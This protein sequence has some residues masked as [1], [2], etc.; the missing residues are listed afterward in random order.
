MTLL[1]GDGIRLC[2]ANLILFSAA[3]VWQCL[4]MVVFGT[5]ARGI[6]DSLTATFCIGKTRLRATSLVIAS[7]GMNFQSA[8]GESCESGNMSF[9]FRIASQQNYFDCFAG[10]LQN[11][12]AAQW[13]TNR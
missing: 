11:R 2:R 1:D 13:L 6:I 5:A 12:I 8:A 7:A 10:E 3:S 9:A 4:W